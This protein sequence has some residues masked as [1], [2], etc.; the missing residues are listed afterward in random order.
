MNLL[1]G[2]YL[3]KVALNLRFHKFGINKSIFG[4]VFG[5]VMLGITLCPHYFYIVQK[6]LYEINKSCDVIFE[7]Y[8]SFQKLS[9]ISGFA[10][11]HIGIISI[12]KLV[13]SFGL[14]VLC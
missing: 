1:F 4:N 8:L 3:L 13:F 7:P 5:P 12:D 14:T 2:N 6:I 10:I 9:K 11:K